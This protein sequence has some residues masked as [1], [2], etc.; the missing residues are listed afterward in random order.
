MTDE[1]RV[2]RDLYPN[3]FIQVIRGYWGI[4][5]ARGERSGEAISHGEPTTEQLIEWNEE[6]G[7]ALQAGWFLCSKCL[8]AHPV[9]EYSCFIMAAKYCKECTSK[10]PELISQANSMSYK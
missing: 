9:S 3:L 8:K 1:Y 7:K 6:A 2:L 5:V 4:W 10:E